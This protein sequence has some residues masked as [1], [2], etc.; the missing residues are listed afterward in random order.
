MRQFAR[1]QDRR[2]FQRRRGRVRMGRKKTKDT[3]SGVRVDFAGNQWL[4]RQVHWEGWGEAHR[5]PVC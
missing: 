2:V 3:A 1:K 4:R 5:A